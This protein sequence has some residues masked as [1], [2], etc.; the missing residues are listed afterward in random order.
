MSTV[1]TKDEDFNCE[2]Y[3]GRFWP[4]KAIVDLLLIT[5]IKERE[6][7]VISCMILATETIVG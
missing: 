5:T 6:F 7:S 1:T 2:L 4:Q 3:K